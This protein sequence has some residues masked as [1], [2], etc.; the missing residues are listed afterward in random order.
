M[1]LCLVAL[2]ACESVRT[3]YDEGGNVV[4]QEEASGGGEKDFTS[5]LEAQFNSSFSEKKT[6]DG[7]PQSVSNKVSSF[8]SKL[9]AA[10]RMDQEYGTGTYAGAARE[11]VYTMSFSGS[12]KTYST[13]DAYS[14][15]MGKRIEK[16]LHPAFAEP[17]RGVVGSEDMFSTSRSAVEGSRSNIG[18]SY[19]T[20]DSVYSHEDTSGYVETRR[21]NTPMPRVMSRDEYYRKTIQ[22]TRTMLGRDKEE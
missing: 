18:G 9:D 10:R 13:K 4:P 3:V 2:C 21:D 7:V 16:D 14:G 19:P 20:H 11:S 5:H 22:Q 12:G 6:E 15:G 17:S 1:L 8:Q